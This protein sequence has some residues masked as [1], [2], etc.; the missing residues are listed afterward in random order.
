M[1]PGSGDSDP[2]IGARSRVAHTSQREQFCRH[3]GG[4]LVAAQ[5]MEVHDEL[6]R[7]M[8]GRRNVDL[9]GDRRTRGGPAGRR[10]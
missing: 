6:F 2:D 9:D 10:D 1:L 5:R 4:E 3:V 8:D 7:R